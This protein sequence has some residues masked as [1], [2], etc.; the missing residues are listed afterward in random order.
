MTITLKPSANS[1]IVNGVKC[2]HLHCAI[3]AVADAATIR[4]PF[5]GKW[6]YLCITHLEMFGTRNPNL[7][8]NIT[9]QDLELSWIRN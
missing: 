3:P 2:D 5:G 8:T 4:G 7:I 6:A 9:G 1:S